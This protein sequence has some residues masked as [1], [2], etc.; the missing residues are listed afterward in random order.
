MHVRGRVVTHVREKDNRGQ[1]EHWVLKL[2]RNKRL[3]ST[4]SSKVDEPLKVEEA[5]IV[6][7]QPPVA[8]K[9]L[10]LGGNGFVG[11]HVCKEA[12][13]RGFPV[14][15]FSRSGRST[16]PESWADEVVWRKG[17]LLDPDSLKDVMNGI[18][19]VISCVGGFGSNSHMFKINGT[20]NI[21]A[22]RA[23]AEMGVKRFVYISAADFGLVNY[24]L[25][26]YYEGKRA[27]EAELLS[28]FTYGGVILRPGFIHGTR[29]VGSMKIPLGVIGSP[30]E[31][32]SAHAAR[33]ASTRGARSARAERGQR[34]RSVVDKHEWS[35]A[36]A[37]RRSEAGERGRSEAG[38][39]GQSEAGSHGRSEA[40]KRE[41]GKA[42]DWPTNP[43]LFPDRLG[44]IRKACSED[45]R[46]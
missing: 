22:I 35:V 37:G 6:K 11:S 41:Q 3:L 23:A 10:V 25:Q 27:T 33:L 38:S 15:S 43:R 17:S 36:G 19:S 39:H 4:D 44:R 29:Q 42:G 5:E 28:K 45:G 34:E 18:I 12:L 32:A 9:L 46:G 31:M 16:I 24:M 7:Q 21:N 8:D 40:D 1:G 26:G 2:L 30:L 20:A 13:H 14:S